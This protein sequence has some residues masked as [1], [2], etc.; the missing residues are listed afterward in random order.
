VGLERGPLA[1]ILAPMTRRQP[2]SRPDDARPDLGYWP[3]RFP[4]LRARFAHLVASVLVGVFVR[5]RV[6]GRDRLPTSSSIL[7][8][9]HLSWADPVVLMAALPGPPQLYFFGPREADMS[10]GARNRLMRW[11]GNAVPYQPDKRDLVEAVRRVQALM[12]AGGALAIAGEGQIHVG[13]S[14]VPPL[15]D[16][17]AFF[18]L[19]A[20]VPVVP[21]AING[22]NWLGFGRRVRL[23]IGDPIDPAGFDR[24]R[25]APELTARVR[26]SLQALVADSPD[27]PP[28]GRFGRWVTEMFNEWPGGSRPPRPWQEV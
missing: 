7:C 4:A 17:A 27:R 23:R 19:R 9:N 25:G 8:F 11:A 22:T 21:V 5:L 26:E 10:V 3:H 20:G 12:V 16:G 18:A 28:P 14:V 1:L 13:E 6:E 2:A 24:R 15:N